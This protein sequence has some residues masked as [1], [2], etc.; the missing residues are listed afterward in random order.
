MHIR[1]KHAPISVIDGCSFV[2]LT[3][4]SDNTRLLGFGKLPYE[5]PTLWKKNSLAQVYDLGLEE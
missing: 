5:I 1:A 2:F 3:G 4:T